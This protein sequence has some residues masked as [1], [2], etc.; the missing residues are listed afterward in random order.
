LIGYQNNR[1]EHYKYKNIFDKNNSILYKYNNLFIKLMILR[2]II[3]GATL[4]GTKQ[5]LHR[6]VGY[7]GS[8]PSLFALYSIEVSSCLAMTGGDGECKLQMGKAMRHSRLTRSSPLTSGST[9]LSPA[10]R[11]LG[12]K[13]FYS[14]LWLAINVIKLRT[15]PIGGQILVEK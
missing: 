15:D 6:R 13:A 10:Q 9:T 1:E 8:P 12:S 3:F 5:P 14:C 4:R 11:G 2:G 7:A